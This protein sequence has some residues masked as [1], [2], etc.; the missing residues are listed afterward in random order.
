MAKSLTCAL[1]DRRWM[2]Q[3]IPVT[4]RNHPV[5]T[6][7]LPLDAPQQPL[8]HSTKT[9]HRRTSPPRPGHTTNPFQC[10]VERIGFATKISN[11]E[12]V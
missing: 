2:L 9:P 8:H 3:H 12:R 4:A 5:T 6:A 1:M 7:P 11:A 10:S